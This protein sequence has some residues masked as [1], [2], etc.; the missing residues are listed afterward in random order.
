MTGQGSDSRAADAVVSEITRAGGRAVADYHSVENGDKIVDAAIR[1]FGRIDV[2]VC[3]AGILR[4]T[5]FAK[6]NDAAWDAV[7]RVH[8]AGTYKCAKAAWQYMRDAGF[9]RIVFVTS[10]SGLYGNFGQANYSAAKMGILG[11]CN[12][13]AKEG[14]PKNICC[15][16]VA[17]IAASRMT[18]GLLPPEL[19]SS[20]TPES[21]AP[22]VAYLCHESCT[23]NGGVFELGGGWCAKLRWQRSGGAYLNPS[24]LT[25]EEV[26]AAWDADVC[27]FESGGGGGGGSGGG[28]AVMYPTSS[29]DAFGP[30]MDNIERHKGRH[31]GSAGEVRRPKL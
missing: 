16:S 20:L 4:D 18:E 28:G 19:Q 5:S 24:S 31:S 26:A 27:D 1:N 21:V 30:M 6:M 15:N 11:L 10:A 17:P 25:V 14:E 8:L 3:N 7:L 22:F 23:T 2:L 29:Q 12:T 13:L 9:G